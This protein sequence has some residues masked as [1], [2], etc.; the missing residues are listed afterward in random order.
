MTVK[1]KLPS[2]RLS[3][4][5]PGE[6]H[7]KLELYLR[8]FGQGAGPNDVMAEALK[9]CLDADKDFRRVWEEECARRAPGPVGI[10]GAAIPAVTV[11]RAG[12][13]GPVP[14]GQDQK[15]SIR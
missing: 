7:A 2:K 5:L 14:S 3:V 8:L 15:G 6:L 13:A 11:P 9:L 10:A 12:S 1:K 4:S